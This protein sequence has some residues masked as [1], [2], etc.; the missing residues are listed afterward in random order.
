MCILIWHI[1][2]YT[3][4]EFTHNCFQF[5]GERHAF[6]PSVIQ[7][8]G[9]ISLLPPPSLQHKYKIPRAHTLTSGLE[10]FLA[11]LTMEMK[12]E[13]T[14]AS[15]SLSWKQA[16]FSCSFRTHRSL[17]LTWEMQWAR[18]RHCRS[19]L[20]SKGKIHCSGTGA[21][22]KGWCTGSLSIRYGEV[23][24]GT[25]IIG[26]FRRAVTSLQRPTYMVP[27]SYQ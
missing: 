18:S 21:C 6:S 10:N 15:T 9:L 14:S 27:I 4:A 8:P 12:E 11:L 5:H 13:N 7:T 17:K 22:Q 3:H 25:S 26:S 23:Y 16:R 19:V 24:S 20:V 1:C 2:W